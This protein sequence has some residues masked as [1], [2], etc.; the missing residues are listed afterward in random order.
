[1]SL[2]GVDLQV[3]Q[4]HH[5]YKCKLLHTMR[6]LGDDPQHYSKTVSQSQHGASQQHQ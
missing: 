1:M 3:P 5:Q 6:R 2:G 4:G